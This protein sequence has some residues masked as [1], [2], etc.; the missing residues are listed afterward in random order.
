MCLNGPPTVS[1]PRMSRRRDAAH[2]SIL[3]S[4]ERPAH[5]LCAQRS[6]SDEDPRRNNLMRLF[7]AA[8]SARSQASSAKDR[9]R[10]AI[11]ERSR[12]IALGPMPW[13]LR[14]S[15]SRTALSCSSRECGRDLRFGEVHSYH[16]PELRRTAHDLRGPR[17]EVT[18]EAVGR[19]RLMRLLAGTK[20]ILRGI[21]HWAIADRLVDPVRGWI[22]EVGIERAQSVTL[23]EKLLG[24]RRDAR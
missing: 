16:T 24:E 9:P 3:P 20:A 17:S 12:P 8:A 22:R 10:A 11:A 1:A 6:R 18:T 2:W 15:D 5:R 13:S 7:D 4:V 23:V 21:A 14:K 19:V